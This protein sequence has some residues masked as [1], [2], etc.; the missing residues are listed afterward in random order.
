MAK[1]TI[2]FH[3]SF[4]ILAFL[5]IY[6]KEYCLLLSMVISVTI[7]ELGHYFVAEKL[8]YRLNVITLMPYGASLS[9]EE[10]FIENK[11]EFLIAIFG[12]ITSFLIAIVLIAFWWIM[13]VT[14]NYTS[15]FVYANLS[16]F[17][18]NLLPC[19]PLDGARALNSILKRKFPTNTACKIIKIISSIVIALLTILYI[20][21]CFNNIN[22]S[23]CIF[24]IFLTIGLLFNENVEKYNLKCRTF[25]KPKNLSSGVSVNI[26]AISNQSNLLELYKLLEPSSINYILVLDKLNNTSMTLKDSDIE[27]ILLKYP[28]DTNLFNIKINK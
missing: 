22:Y 8:G 25:S 20:I 6:F 21:S 1:L 2:K 24:T 10:L 14:Y 16:I 11:H 27:N 3:W 19:F 26:K 7:H 9:G 5:L 28:L 18:V 15:T 12:P 4:W 23:L 13:P 17:L